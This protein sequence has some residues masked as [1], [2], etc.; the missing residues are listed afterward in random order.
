MQLT[1][2]IPNCN[3]CEAC[4]VA[5]K[6]ACVKMEKKDGAKRPVIN[7]NG[8]NKCNSCVLYCPLYNPVELPEFED[9]F[10][11]EENVRER[12]MAPIYRAT[13]RSVKSGQHTEFVGTLCQIAALKSL[14][15]D[16]L[17]HNLAI[18][19][20]YCDEEQRSSCDAC[21]ACGFYK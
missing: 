5:C 18:F 19:P 11:S 8:C 7:E 17:S 3:G 21:R 2:R 10:D 4:I 14:R 15:G 16:R 6:Y 12:E 13:M 9:L 20:I 1:D